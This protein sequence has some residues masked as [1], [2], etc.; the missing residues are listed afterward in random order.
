VA[1][2]TGGWIE[3][4]ILDITTGNNSA[5]YTFATPGDYHWVAGSCLAAQV[6]QA[7]GGATPNDYDLTVV[8]TMVA[9]N[10]SPANPWG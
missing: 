8:V 10:T 6:I 3:V 7:G 5:T 1:Y 9:N 4:T 2:N